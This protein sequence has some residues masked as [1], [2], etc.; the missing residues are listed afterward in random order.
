MSKQH[1]ARRARHHGFGLLA[2]AA[3]LVW[4]QAGSQNALN[5]RTAHPVPSVSKP[6]PIQLAAGAA[7]GATQSVTP[8]RST[9]RE[10]GGGGGTGATPNGPG[11]TPQSPGPAGSDNTS[12]T[13]PSARP[14][15]GGGGDPDN[16]MVVPI[17][18]GDPN[19]I[20]GVGGG[21][22]SPA[23]S[24]NR[25]QGGGGGGGG[26]I[27]PFIRVIPGDQE[28]QPIDRPTGSPAGT[29]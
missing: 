20:D 17:H 19:G 1:G 15:G 29:R 26:M 9:E 6:V 25:D 10:G 24:P 16:R 8:G 14:S 3:A 5:L 23:A 4:T 2:V 27:N 11:G 18:G 12:I 13:E 21:S 28:V 22:P 7:T